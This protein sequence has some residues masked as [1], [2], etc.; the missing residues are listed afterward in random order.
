MSELLRSVA[1]LG[2]VSYTKMQS[3]SKYQPQPVVSQIG[4]FAA[5]SFLLPKVNPIPRQPAG[6]HKDQRLAQIPTQSVAP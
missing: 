4:W 5:D 3:L 6:F 1:D 2:T